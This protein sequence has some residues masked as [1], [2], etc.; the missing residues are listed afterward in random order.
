MPPLQIIFFLL[1]HFEI[2]ELFAHLLYHSTLFFILTKAAFHLAWYPH[3]VILL[4]DHWTAS[5]QKRQIVLRK[6]GCFVEIHCLC[7]LSIITC[8]L[9]SQVEIELF[10]DMKDK[11]LFLR[12][13]HVDEALVQ[14]YMDQAVDIFKL[15]TVGPQKYVQMLFIVCNW[16][17]SGQCW[18]LKISNK[19][20]L[21]CKYT[22]V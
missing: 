21:H 7:T 14:D 2:Q 3:A 18:R 16:N 8:S 5:T 20:W 11:K 17:E 10:P 4:P 22:F 13:V 19:K 12:S 15:N 1:S 6:H 9:S